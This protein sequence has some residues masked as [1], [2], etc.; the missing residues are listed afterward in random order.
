MFFLKFLHELRKEHL[1]PSDLATAS[2][3][4]EK[5]IIELCKVLCLSN[6]QAW[7]R[8]IG[9]VLDISPSE[10]HLRAAV[11]S[12]RRSPNDV[13]ED[14]QGLKTAL[15]KMCS[16][17]LLV[18]SHTI[19]GLE[20]SH[21]CIK[22]NQYI[23]LPPS[24]SR[25]LLETICR[26]LRVSARSKS[27]TH[28][29]SLSAIEIEAIV[30]DIMPLIELQHVLELLPK[31]DY[32][33]A[34]A[35]SS[36]NAKRE[37][38]EDFL[39]DALLSSVTS[40]EAIHH[41]YRFLT[42]EN[43]PSLVNVFSDACKRIL[44]M[45]K[46]E[47]MLSMETLLK[48]PSTLLS[49][50]EI[51]ELHNN[52]FQML[53][54]C[55]EDYGK[56]LALAWVF[57]EYDARSANLVLL[58]E[59][60]SIIQLIKFDESKIEAPLSEK[61]VLNASSPEGGGLY[62]IGIEMQRSSLLDVILQSLNTVDSS[63][64]RKVLQLMRA[65]GMSCTVT[66]D[67]LTRV[68]AVSTLRPKDSIF[69]KSRKSAKFQKCWERFLSIARAYAM[70]EIIL[71]VLLVDVNIVNW[72]LSFESDPVNETGFLSS[73][74]ALNEWVSFMSDRNRITIEIALGGKM[75][76]AASEKIK[77]SDQLDE[78]VSLLIPVTLS[79]KVLYE[80]A[81]LHSIVGSVTDRYSKRISFCC[82]DYSIRENSLQRLTLSDCIQ[83]FC[84]HALPMVLSPLQIFMKL[85]VE[86]HFYEAAQ[87]YW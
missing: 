63:Q 19:S 60:K 10:M 28:N 17:H 68:W 82:E 31:D 64:M 50:A 2:D 39:I 42:E 9:R 77:P 61:V 75:A 34:K 1:F 67:E 78:I 76:D 13:L 36:I 37:F 52:I 35:K 85:C 49:D 18:L 56:Y 41:L 65:W 14:L 23:S 27:T 46:A 71:E 24:I 11:E 8:A 53:T 21:Q 16:D 29:S 74:H 73:P 69:S 40:P 20:Y 84:G 47:A 79:G 30:K 80:F 5:G 25:E 6:V 45:Q 66:L 83:Y 54:Q 4:R 22:L 58:L 70:E 57:K 44:N 72:L 62:D 26:G 7:G 48:R 15:N 12:I 59:S 87:L 3:A 51:E 33:H 38:K 43:F 32:F 55:Q 86:G 81:H